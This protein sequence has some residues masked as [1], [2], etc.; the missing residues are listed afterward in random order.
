MQSQIEFTKL[1]TTFPITKY[2]HSEV[3]Y[4]KRQFDVAALIFPVCLSRTRF[5]MAETPDTNQV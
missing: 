5:L 1:V 3:W 2:A 4:W